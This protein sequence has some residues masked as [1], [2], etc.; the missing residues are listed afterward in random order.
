MG[1]SEANDI[2]L[3]REARRGLGQMWTSWWMLGRCGDW[4][5]GLKRAEQFAEYGI[6]WLEEPLHPEDVEGYAH[7]C[8]R[9]PVPIATGEAES[10][11]QDFERLLVKGRIDWVQP[12]P[13]RC[14]L[15]TMVE[16]GRLAHRLHRK[17]VNHSFKSGITIAASLHGL[18]AVPHGEVFEYCMAESPLRPRPDVRKI[19]GR[20]WLRSRAGGAGDWA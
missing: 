9:S 18:A 12:D 15:S 19:R 11:Y 3:V 7:L 20:R 16:V 8:E 10:R 2:A 1:Q 6:F 4:K 13:G 14:G 17:V 5:T